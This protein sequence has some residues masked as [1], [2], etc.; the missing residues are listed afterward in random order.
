M[1]VSDDANALLSRADLGRLA[2]LEPFWVDLAV[3]AGLLVPVSGSEP[4]DELF[5]PASADMLV[6][7]KTL[8]SEGVNVEELAALAM[9]HAANVEAVIDDAIDVFKA[10][11]GESDRSERFASFERL[12]PV[13]TKLVASHF[14]QTLTA[15]VTARLDDDD[16]ASADVV[17]V[18]RRLDE[19][20]DLLDIY[21][22]LPAGEQVAL[23]LSPPTSILAIGEV[24]VIAPSGVDRFAGASA[25]RAALEARVRREGAPDAPS[26]VLVGGFSFDEGNTWPDDCRLVLAEITIIQRPDGTWLQLAARGSRNS[27]DA[28]IGKLEQK[29]NSLLSSSSK[30][31]QLRS[32]TT[33][34]VVDDILYDLTTDPDYEQIVER[35]VAALNNG[36]LNSK[37]LDPKKLDPKKLDPKKLDPKKLDPKKLDPKKLDPKK[38]DPK[39]LD[40]KKLDKVVVARA[41]DVVV[42]EVVND[43]SLLASILGHLQQQNPECA[44]FAF[45]VSHGS[46]FIGASPEELVTLQGKTIHTTALAGTARRGVTGAEDER[47]AQALLGSDK[48]RSEHRFVVDGIVAVLEKLGLV[49]PTSSEPEVMRLSGVQHLCTPISAQVQHRRTQMSDMDVLRVAGALHPTPA[50][51]G[52]PTSAALEFIGENEGFNRGW[53]AA[54][55]GWCDLAGNGEMRVGLRCGLLTGNSLRLFAG[56]GIVADSV[57]QDE[58]AETTLKFSALVTALVSAGVRIEASAVSSAQEQR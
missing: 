37:K 47:L 55:V 24:E 13:A 39:K 1:S 30:A 22:A 23:W 49:E 33:P 11:V 21:A 3:Q 6:S 17:C 54:P 51:G 46:V 57:P 52:T 36:K 40:P 15:R 34:S 18:T 12:V 56:A 7:A 35:A 25:A 42:E 16:A 53:Y 41:V 26:P 29:A 38:L 8:M 10:N 27:N 2:D 19:P 9:R 50:V 20:V 28:L 4:D 44:T 14:E 45:D 31:E 5:E 43:P 48:E 58:L 32:S